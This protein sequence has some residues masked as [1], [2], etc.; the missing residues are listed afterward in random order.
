MYSTFRGLDD[1]D[2]DEDSNEKDK[3]KLEEKENDMEVLTK[4]F[5]CTIF[6]EN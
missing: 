3:I 5:F 2:P 4:Y 6:L 1:L